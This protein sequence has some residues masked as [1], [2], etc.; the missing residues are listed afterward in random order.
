LKSWGRERTRDSF[1]FTS[2]TNIST[3]ETVD[4]KVSVNHRPYLDFGGAGGAYIQNKVVTS[5][6]SN[7][8]QTIREAVSRASILIDYSAML[9]GRPQNLIAL[10]P[11]IGIETSKP[12]GLDVD[13]SRAPKLGQIR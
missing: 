9:A 8:G 5:I 6:R 3:V 10:G 11:R 7:A 1:I 12:E 4:G 2:K 13:L